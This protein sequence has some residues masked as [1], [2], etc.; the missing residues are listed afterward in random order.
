MFGFFVSFSLY[1]CSVYTKTVRGW[2]CFYDYYSIRAIIL[3]DVVKWRHYKR[4]YICVKLGYSHWVLCTYWI[5]DWGILKIN[6]QQMLQL[7]Y[8]WTL[9]V[10]FSN[11]RWWVLGSESLHEEV[12]LTFMSNEK[13]SCMSVDEIVTR[14]YCARIAIT[15]SAW[16]LMRLW[17]DI[18]ARVA[19]TL[20]AW[21]LMS[22]CSQTQAR[23]VT[24][25]NN[26]RLSAA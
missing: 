4:V 16:E 24:L 9:Q 14:Y 19:I 22:V 20:S 10:K 25:I 7:N 8:L 26:L 6:F 3:V 13:K 1:V 12:F 21:E 15:L 2:N 23:V 11:E 17:L 18:T 5:P